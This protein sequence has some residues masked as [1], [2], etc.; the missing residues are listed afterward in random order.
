MAV[1]FVIAKA[2]FSHLLRKYIERSDFYI[3][4]YLK[5]GAKRDLNTL[6]EATVLIKKE[7]QA[8]ESAL[9]LA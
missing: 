7:I 8:S 4:T 6:H 1:P 9:Y 3:L 5:K 2:K